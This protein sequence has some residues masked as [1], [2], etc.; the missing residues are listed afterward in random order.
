MSRRQLDIGLA[1]LENYPFSSLPD[2]NDII[3][4]SRKIL[5][6]EVFKIYQKKTTKQMMENA[7]SYAETFSD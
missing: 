2:F 4:P 3:R 5:G 6:E 1:K 7:L